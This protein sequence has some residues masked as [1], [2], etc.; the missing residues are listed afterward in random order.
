MP[1]SELTNYKL[2][3]SDWI[4]HDT[5]YNQVSKTNKKTQ[6]L[7][8]G[9]CKDKSQTGSSVSENQLTPHRQHIKQHSIIPFPMISDEEA[10]AG[11]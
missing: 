1:G 9:V 8:W 6:H 10:D 2:S 7:F 4:N 11:L 5:Y 3:V